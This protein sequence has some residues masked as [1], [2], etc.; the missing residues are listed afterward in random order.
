MT[1]D[2]ECLITAPTLEETSMM[3]AKLSAVA[4]EHGEVQTSKIE[5]C[6][7]L[8]EDAYVGQF[9][10]SVATSLLTGVAANAIWAWLTTNDK[11]EKQRPEQ[12]SKQPENAPDFNKP[13]QIKIDTV[14]ITININKDG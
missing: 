10:L 8:F 5:K 6:A 12:S 4:A 3:L 1:A 13:V 9:L 14:N 11:Q 2:I 7:G